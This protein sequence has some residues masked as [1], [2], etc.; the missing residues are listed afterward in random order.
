MAASWHLAFQAI[1]QLG[2]Q[3]PCMAFKASRLPWKHCAEQPLWE[4]LL[5]V[6]GHQNAKTS[7]SKGVLPKHTVMSC[8][9]RYRSR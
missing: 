9:L 3:L 2:L 4:A 7:M 6:G 8:I 5:I 1:L